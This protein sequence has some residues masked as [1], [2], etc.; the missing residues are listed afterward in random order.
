MAI[1]QRKTVPKRVKKP[2]TPPE[3]SE[4]SAKARDAKKTFGKAGNKTFMPKTAQTSSRTSKTRRKD[5]VSLSGRV[6]GFFASLGSLFGR[7]GKQVKP[8]TK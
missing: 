7:S 5:D 2:M 6:N 3:G 1:K 4:V 8:R